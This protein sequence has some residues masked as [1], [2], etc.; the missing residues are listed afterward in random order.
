MKLKKRTMSKESA[1]DEERLRLAPMAEAE[2]DDGR[3][4]IKVGTEP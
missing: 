1:T 3:V 4:T 2:E